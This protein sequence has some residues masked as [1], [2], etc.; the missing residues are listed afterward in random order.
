MIHSLLRSL[1]KPQRMSE[2]DSI[3]LDDVAHAKDQ[4]IIS[5]LYTAPKDCQILDKK[6]WKVANPALGNFRSLQDIKDFAQQADRLPAKAK[7]FSL[8]VP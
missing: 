7:L 6:A 3:W 8:V 4:R 1:R 5:H 2:A